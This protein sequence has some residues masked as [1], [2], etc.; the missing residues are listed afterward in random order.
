MPRVTVLG[1]SDEKW[2]ASF[3]QSEEAMSRVTAS[4]MFFQGYDN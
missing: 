4:V 3:N 1:T 2:A